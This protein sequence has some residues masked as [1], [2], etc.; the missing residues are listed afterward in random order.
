[1]AN[2]QERLGQTVG[3]YRLLQRLG[4]GGFGNVY[5]AEHLHNQTH[6]AIKILE[7]RLT[8]A[9]DW[10]SFLNEARMFRLH[11][12][13]IMP[14]LDFG[15]SRQ[16]EPFLVMDYAPNGTLRDRHPKGSRVPLAHHCPLRDSSGLCL[17]VC[18]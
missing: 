4:G 15:I 1:M 17:A 13:H 12:P 16:D 9:D 3:D 10:R 2:Q 11:H 18:P 5:L 14:L 7:M 8:N 6:V